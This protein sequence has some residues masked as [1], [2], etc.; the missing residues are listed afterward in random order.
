MNFSYWL[1]WL[2]KSVLFYG[3]WI[4][5][6]Q[7]V[8]VCEPYKGVLVIGAILIYLFIVSDNRPA[9]FILV[10]SLTVMGAM[11]DTAYALTGMIIY[12]CP[13]PDFPWI[14]PYWLI[15]LWMLFAALI[16][17]SFAWLNGRWLLATVLGSAGGVSSY[18]GSMRMGAAEFGVSAT[19]GITVLAIVWAIIV[20]ASVYYSQWLDKITRNL[21]IN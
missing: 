12:N 14:A 3:G 13:F 17:E 19:I 10:I 16:R 8:N 15:S 20:P 7:S 11:T 21:K 6:L 4:Y 9:D 2:I 18:L 5:C 1:S